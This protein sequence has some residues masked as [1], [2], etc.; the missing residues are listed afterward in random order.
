PDAVLVLDRDDVDT[1]VQRLGGG[2]VV[3]AFVLADAVVDLVRIG[4]LR[5]GMVEHGDLSRPVRGRGEVTCEGRDP[6]AARRVGRD[7]SCS[8]DDETPRSWRRGARPGQ[9]S[10]SR[11]SLAR[12]WQPALGGWPGR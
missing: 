8:N 2:D 10:E 9:R 5:S 3:G 6:A 4:R 12:W 11:P 1:P 7:E